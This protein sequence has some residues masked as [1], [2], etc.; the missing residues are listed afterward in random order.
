M[1]SG[2]GISILPWIELN[3]GYEA[4]SMDHEDLGRLWSVGRE[5]TVQDIVGALSAGA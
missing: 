5:I 1:A 2:V 4:S 3:R